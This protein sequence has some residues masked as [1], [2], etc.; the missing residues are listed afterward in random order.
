[1]GASGGISC[2]PTQDCRRAP[3]LHAWV[4][5]GGGVHARASRQT[6]DQTSKSG[7][8]REAPEPSNTFPDLIA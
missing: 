5:S 4:S 7:S 3:A 8:Y 2:T 6:C 1:M